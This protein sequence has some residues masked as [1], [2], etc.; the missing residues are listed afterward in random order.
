[1]DEQSGGHVQQYTKHTLYNIDKSPSI[2]SFLYSNKNNDGHNT[3]LC[4]PLTY[5]NKPQNIK[6]SSVP[7]N[8]PITDSGININDIYPRLKKFIRRVSQNRF[9]ST[10][11]GP[12]LVFVQQKVVQ[13]KL[14]KYTQYHLDNGYLQKM[15]EQH[16]VYQA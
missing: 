12:Y 2:N 5:T 14:E 8:I 9:K 10:H 7:N 6:Q 1:M 13:I 4:K 11:K 16:R 15:N 3:A